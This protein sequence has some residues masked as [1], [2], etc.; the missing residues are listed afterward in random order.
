MSDKCISLTKSPQKPVFLA[1]ILQNLNFLKSWP[2][3]YLNDCLLLRNRNIPARFQKM[4]SSRGVWWL[5]IIKSTE[6]INNMELRWRI[7]FWYSIFFNPVLG[8]ESLP[9]CVHLWIWIPLSDCG[10]CCPGSHRLAGGT[11]RCPYIGWNCCWYTL[12]ENKRIVAH[13]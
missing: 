2:F 11:A 8:G 7:S 1:W 10:A 3:W 12:K 9:L 5:N 6:I 13:N 4:L